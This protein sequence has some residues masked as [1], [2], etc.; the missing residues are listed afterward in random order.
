MALPSEPRTLRR[1]F[2]GYRGSLGT[3]AIVLVEDATTGDQ[4]GVLT[5]R[6]TYSPT[7]FNWGYDGAGPRELAR[8][9]LAAVLGAAADC[10][11]CH[12]RADASCGGLQGRTAAGP[13]GRATGP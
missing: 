6:G 11:S 12:G 8:S 13:A 2:R 4:V 10:Q 9:L 5:H 1:R 3:P 7:G